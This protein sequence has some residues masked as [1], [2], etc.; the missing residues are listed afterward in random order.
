MKTNKINKTKKILTLEQAKLK[1]NFKSYPDGVYSW[2]NG[3]GYYALVKNGVDVLRGKK[4]IHCGYNSAGG[5]YR[6]VDKQFEWHKERFETRTLFTF[7]VKEGQPMPRLRNC[8]GGVFEWE[9]ESGVWHEEKLFFRMW[10]DEQG[11]WHRG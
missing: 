7:I 1:P 8:G 5:F 9:D 3:W 2:K 6:W 10:Q 4:A 11:G